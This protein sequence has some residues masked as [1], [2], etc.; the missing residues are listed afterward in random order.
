M[1]DRNR[2]SKQMIHRN[3]IKI[4][5]RNGLPIKAAEAGK[6]ACMAVVD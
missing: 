5:S 3:G 4:A 2:R 1:A 6:V